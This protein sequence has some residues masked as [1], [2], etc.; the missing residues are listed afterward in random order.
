[1]ERLPLLRDGEVLELALLREV[2]VAVRVDHDAP[3]AFPLDDEDVVGGEVV[4][5]RLAGLGLGPAARLGERRVLAGP[6]GRRRGARLLRPA[7]RRRVALAA[8]R[9]EAL[10]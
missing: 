9:L 4:G 10:V 3:R 2:A 8:L 5:E 1:M 7:E 6:R